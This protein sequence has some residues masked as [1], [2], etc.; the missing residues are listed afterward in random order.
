MFIPVQPLP[1]K[2]ARYQAK[3]DDGFARFMALVEDMST[4]SPI[5]S[6]KGVRC[7]EGAGDM[8]AA[9]G[10]GVLDFP[11][12]VV[13]D[14]ISD[15]ATAKERD[16]GI[17]SLTRVTQ[18]DEQTA[19]EHMVLKPVWPTDARDFVNLAH[20]RVLPDGNV[21]AFGVGIEDPGVPPQSGVLPPGGRLHS[22]TQHSQAVPRACFAV[23]FFLLR[24]VAQAS[25]E[26]ALKS[27]AGSSALT[28]AA[29]PPCARTCSSLTSAAT[30]PSG[31][32]RRAP[33]PKP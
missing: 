14:Y 26:A 1:P 19:I 17:A 6:S 30:C 16:E 32:S 21:A 3:L 2:F 5:K 18:L 31:W 9:R 25:F 10:D 4:W 20:V 7:Y 12:R 24:G 22:A 11:P 27:V 28:T 13:V 15:P 23:V 29:S 33:P 8:P